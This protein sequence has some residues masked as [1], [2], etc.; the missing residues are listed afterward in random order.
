VRGRVSG[1]CSTGKGIRAFDRGMKTVD[2][3]T[4]RKHG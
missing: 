2:C 3:S 4:R 1:I